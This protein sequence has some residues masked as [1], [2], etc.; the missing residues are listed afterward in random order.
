MAD[1]AF[2]SASELLHLLNERKLTS[3]ELLEFYLNRIETYNGQVNAV[4]YLDLEGARQRADLADKAR[5]GGQNW[6]VLHGLPMTVK[7]VNN[8]A[9]W[10]TTYGDPADADWRPERNAALIDRLIGAGAIIFGKTNIPLHSADFQSFNAIY[11]STRNPW[12]LARSPGGSSGGSAAALAA[13][14]TP[15]EL[16]TDIAGSIRFPAHFCGVFGHKPTHGILSDQ[17]NLRRG[18]WLKSDLSTAG[19]LA[20]SAAD[21]ELLLDVLAGPDGPAAKAWQL[22][23]P[24]PRAT[25]L[26]DFRIGLIEDSSIAPI[27]SAYRSAIGNFVDQLEQAG[28]SVSRRAQ[29]SLDHAE[30][31]D[32]YIKL[33]RGTGA[34]RMSPAEFAAALDI[35]AA[36]SDADNS[37]RAQLRRAQ[38]QTHRS[39]IAA[40]EIRARLNLEWARFFESYDVLLCPVTL[41]AAYPVDE[42]TIREDRKI[43]VS[44]QPVDYNDQLFWAGYS[45]M[46]SLPVTTI[47]IGLLPSG[48]PVGI[49]VIGPYL[50]DRTTLAFAKAVSTLAKFIPPPGFS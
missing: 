6:G 26:G 23:L 44:G 22:E 19:P 3:R 31:H 4:V 40:E 33:L 39:Y 41:S 43:L 8:V 27:D 7:D 47:P 1:L 38:T 18:A 11:G 50:E 13:G 48:L 42:T 34:G 46:P 20:R 32:A 30:A 16:G 10:P 14:F 25:A 49:N 37:Y 15:V 12:D 36:L 28:A 24:A 17:G 35:A 5:A 9:G 45:T 29:P 2:A 21:L